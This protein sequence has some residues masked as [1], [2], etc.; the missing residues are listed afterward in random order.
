ANDADQGRRPRSGVHGRAHGAELDRPDVEARVDGAHELQEA[1][2]GV[3]AEAP[4]ADRDE[5]GAIEHR[6][7]RELRADIGP[8]QLGVRRADR[9]GAVPHEDDGADQLALD[10]QRRDRAELASMWIATHPTSLARPPEDSQ[11]P[12]PASPWPPPDLRAPRQH[13]GARERQRSEI[14]LDGRA[15]AWACGARAVAVRPRVARS[16]A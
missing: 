10:E 8:Q 15:G 1:E 3:V 12:R 11:L 16:P 2:P 13:P 6:R 14:A 4:V 5:L 7:D 9:P